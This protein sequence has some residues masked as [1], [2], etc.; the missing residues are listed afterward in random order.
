MPCTATA[1][2]SYTLCSLLMTNPFCPPRLIAVHLS[3]CHTTHCVRK[4][5]NASTA[6]SAPPF[7]I[8][9][10]AVRARDILGPMYHFEEVDLQSWPKTTGQN[11]RTHVFAQS[12]HVPEP[13]QM[14][15]CICMLFV[16][17]YMMTGRR[18]CTGLQKL[19]S[20]SHA[21][22][23]RYLQGYRLLY[24]HPLKELLQVHSLHRPSFHINH[25][26]SEFVASAE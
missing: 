3:A 21:A 9:G 20:F 13:G 7:K 26:T 19:T 15:A 17:L 16:G 1:A 18:G 24:W 14:A 12:P 6:P 22:T 8:T 11:N 23:D 25:Q 2:M 5:S 4:K 10:S